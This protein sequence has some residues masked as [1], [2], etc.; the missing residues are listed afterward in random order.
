MLLFQKLGDTAMIAASKGT[1][2]LTVHHFVFRDMAKS[3]TTVYTCGVAGDNLLAQP[4]AKATYTRHTSQQ[5][6]TRALS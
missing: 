6:P 3:A 5:L 2:T 1:T 4:S